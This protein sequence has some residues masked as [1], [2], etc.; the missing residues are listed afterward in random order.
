E[1]VDIILLGDVL[2]CVRSQRWLRGE[3]RPWHNPHSAPYLATVSQITTDILHENESSL[4][5]LRS[6]AEPGGLTIPTAM[7]GSPRTSPHEVQ[8]VTVRIHYLVGNHDWFYHLPGPHYDMLRGLVV[9]QMGLA[10]RP[11]EP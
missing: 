1:Q 3:V 6:L 10:N 11:A 8:P 2:D 7:R 5:V 9:R 4:R